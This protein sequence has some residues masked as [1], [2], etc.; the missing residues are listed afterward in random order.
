[1]SKSII[2][3]QTLY[4]TQLIKIKHFEDKDINSIL[5]AMRNYKTSYQELYAGFIPENYKSLDKNAAVRLAICHNMTSLVDDYLELGADKNI[6]FNEASGRCNIPIILKVVNDIPLRQRH[7][8]ISFLITKLI[9]RQR[10]K[11]ILEMLKYIP[12]QHNYDIFFKY[13]V[14]FEHESMLK[15]MNA[16]YIGS[17]C[18]FLIYASENEHWKSF[19]YLLDNY[20][21]PL[22]LCVKNVILRGR[23]DILEVITKKYP[24]IIPYVENYKKICESLKIEFEMST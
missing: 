7:Q 12:Y 20:K 3:K 1:M 10:E 18:P 6:V 24:A 22:S 14:I 5:S 9:E 17:R 15:L 19:L 4:N 11:D 8:T 2:V 16:I 21:G 13:A 23:N